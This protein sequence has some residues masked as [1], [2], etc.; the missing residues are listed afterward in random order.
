MYSILVEEI[1]QEVTNIFLDAKVQ[2]VPSNQ[3]IR[4]EF[5][6]IDK[7]YITEHMIQTV[8]YRIALYLDKKYPTWSKDGHGHVDGLLFKLSTYGKC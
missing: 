4:E 3:E 7:V 8:Q 1:T 5:E 2:E 6:I